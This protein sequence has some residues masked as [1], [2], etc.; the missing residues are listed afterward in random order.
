MRAQ[1][2]VSSSTVRQRRVIRS[3]TKRMVNW[4]LPKGYELIV[5][6]DDFKISLHPSRPKMAAMDG[7]PLRFLMKQDS[8]RF[9]F[10]GGSHRIRN[11]LAVPIE[12]RERMRT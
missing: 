2:C 1:T 3:V 12:L 11:P 10:S 6:A 7:C 8:D 4:R 5:L 9:S